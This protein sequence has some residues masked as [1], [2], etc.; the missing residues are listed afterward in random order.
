[1]TGVIPHPVSLTQ[2]QEQGGRQYQVLTDRF[3]FY[4]ASCNG[5]PVAGLDIS[6]ETMAARDREVTGSRDN[7]YVS[8][9]HRLMAETIRQSRRGWVGFVEPCNPKTK[10]RHGGRTELPS[11]KQQ[12]GQ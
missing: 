5:D 9:P 10:S 4:F 6:D 2:C 1:M 12:T 3:C 8:A 11:F 7:V